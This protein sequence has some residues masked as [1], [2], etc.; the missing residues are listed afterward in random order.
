MKQWLCIILG[1]CLTCSTWL[2]PSKLCAQECADCDDSDETLWYYYP[3]ENGEFLLTVP[4]SSTIS[5]NI[6]IVF[7]AVGLGAI[8]GMIAGNVASKNNHKHHDHGHKHKHHHG[9]HHS[10]RSP[11][12]NFSF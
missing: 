4:W 5:T 8:A 3:Y 6:V 2:E 7:L 10:V 11:G 1:F 9:H 12:V